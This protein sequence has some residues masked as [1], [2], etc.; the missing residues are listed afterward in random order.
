MIRRH[1]E[2]RRNNHFHS[3]AAADRLSARQ[4]QASLTPG[5][6]R[7]FLV[8]RRR[9][10]A[11]HVECVALEPAGPNQKAGKRPVDLL[12]EQFDA[13][14]LGRVMAGDQQADAQ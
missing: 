10:G 5:P 9:T 3:P 4:A 2:K 12:G 13:R 14:S 1:L 11:N 6:S 8:N 7:G